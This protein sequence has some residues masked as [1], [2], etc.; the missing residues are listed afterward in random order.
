M[1]NPDLEVISEDDNPEIVDELM[2][3]T[4]FKQQEQFDDIDQIIASIQDEL[5]IIEEDDSDRKELEENLSKVEKQCSELE[6]KYN[7]GQETFQKL[8]Q[9]Y[10][11]NN[12][13]L[14]KMRSVEALR[15]L[16]K[17]V[18]MH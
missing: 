11:D 10:F 18:I 14:I 2:E 9:L 3:E 12:L 8:E 7:E 5:K 15:D 13:D 6:G 4:A 16:H 17:I 1:D